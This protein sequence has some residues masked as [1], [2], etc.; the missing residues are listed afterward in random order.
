MN[1]K[2][3]KDNLAKNKHLNTCEQKHLGGIDTKSRSTSLPPPQT[4]KSNKNM[5]EKP[6]FDGKLTI[7]KTNFPNKIK[8]NNTLEI[9][10][11]NNN[12]NNLNISC[13]LSSKQLKSKKKSVTKS[14]RR[15]SHQPLKRQSF[16]ILNEAESSQRKPRRIQSSIIKLQM[17]D[18]S[19]TI[20]TKASSLQT[21]KQ[22]SKIKVACIK[23]NPF[24]TIFE[25][26]L[27][28][29]KFKAMED[30]KN[31]LRIL[32]SD[33]IIKSKEIALELINKYYRPIDYNNSSNYKM[34]I[35]DN[36][37][38]INEM[39]SVF[40]SESYLQTV[41]SIKSKFKKLVLKRIE[42]HQDRNIINIDNV[43]KSTFNNQNNNNNNNDDKN[44]NY[45]SKIKEES[46]NNWIGAKHHK[47]KLTTFTNKSSSLF[48][49]FIDSL[50][51]KFSPKRTECYTFLVLD[52]DE[53]LIH[54]EPLKNKNDLFK[55]K[56]KF[57]IRIQSKRKGSIININIHNDL[58]I[59]LEMLAKEFFL[60]LFSGGQK[61]YIEEITTA[62]NI[63]QYFSL[64]LNRKYC[65]EVY[66]N[67]MVKDLAIFSIFDEKRNAK[68]EETIGINEQDGLVYGGFSQSFDSK[69]VLLVDNSIYSFANNLSQGV[70]AKSFFENNKF[71]QD[72]LIDIYRL[73]KQLKTSG[74]WL[75]NSPD[76]QPNK[77]PFESDSIS[78]PQTG[79]T[80]NNNK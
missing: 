32:Q 61:D 44:T 69:R 16:I 25:S 10:R 51:L 60:V 54:S 52:L 45:N 43:N 74:F 73:I 75:A 67:I 9:S 8:Q 29:K 18:L 31:C 27:M 56:E 57:D 80:N 47:D 62:L 78:K 23:Q 65:I 40:A 53:L 15:K 59:F 2:S 11:S 1:E 48:E 34:Y 6:P 72:N 66:D 70:L 14:S 37:K 19:T 46:N 77:V 33:E 68:K 22:K 50:Q 5:I 71:S 21:N 49:R 41:E 13:L 24:K 3:D 12:L 58:F 28:I 39:K 26:K 4:L 35:D 64:I 63:K 20:S 79:N 7:F 42:E 38:I 55:S 76:C 30:V 17:R 36:L